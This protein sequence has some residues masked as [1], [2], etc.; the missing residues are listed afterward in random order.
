M[1]S[2]EIIIKEKHDEHSARKHQ[3]LALNEI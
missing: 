3:F 1:D 2:I